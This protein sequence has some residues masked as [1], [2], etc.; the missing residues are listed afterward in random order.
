MTPEQ[1]A[2]LIK[3]VHSTNIDLLFIFFAMCFWI[4]MSFKK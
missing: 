1:A 3:A 2:E 4:G